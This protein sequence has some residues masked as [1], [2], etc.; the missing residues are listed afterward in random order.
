[1]YYV[2]STNLI[3]YFFLFIL[4]TLYLLL[5]T[6]PASALTMSNDNYILQMGNFN[7]SSGK[8]TGDNYKMGVTTGQT[9]PGL[10]TGTN[11]KVRS[12]FQYIHSVIAFAFSITNTDINFGTLTANNPVTRTSNLTIS[13]GSAAGY[14]VTAS[15]NHQLLVPAT[16]AIIPDTTCDDGTCT[17]STSAAWTNSL[18]YGF[19]YRCDNVTGTDCAS[20]FTTSTFYKQFDASPSAKT[21]MSGANVGRNKETQITYKVN[22]STTQAAGLYTNIIM[23]IATPTF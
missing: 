21:V 2:S 3:K 23:Y 11:Y 20:G 14:S 17:E 12:G 5:H 7:M 15:E 16:G 9:G 19:G 10:Y 1:M 13:N 4:T 18:T 8:P 22:I 6:E